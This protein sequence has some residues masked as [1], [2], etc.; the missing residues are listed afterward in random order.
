MVGWMESL[1]KE[2]EVEKENR[3]M[4]V[5]DLKKPA[6]SF[7]LDAHIT[8]VFMKVWEAMCSMCSFHNVEF[9]KLVGE[10]EL[11]HLRRS[12]KSMSSV[13]CTS[14]YNVH[15]ACE[16]EN[17]QYDVLSPDGMADSVLFCKWVMRQAAHG[18]LN[19][20]PFNF[21]LVIHYTISRKR[22]RRERETVMI[23]KAVRLKML[24]RR[25][26][27]IW[28]SSVFRCTTPELWE[29]QRQ[30]MSVG[31]LIKLTYERRLCTFVEVSHHM[32][33]CFLV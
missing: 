20:S 9:G 32:E 6:G 23:L 29:A 3:V 18:H 8:E 28:V 11:I 25:R 7:E 5:V 24:R 17:L 16:D 30:A 27:E 21:R 12:L 4:E 19:S 13:L 10:H 22:G 31:K 26:K 33:M 2:V 1:N 14:P 15:H